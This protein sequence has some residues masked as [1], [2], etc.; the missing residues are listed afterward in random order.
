MERRDIMSGKDRDIIS[1]LRELVKNVNELLEATMADVT[2]EQAHWIPP[3]V[4]MPIGAHY[5][6]VVLSQDGAVNGMLKG[7]SPLFAAAW[8]AKTELSE[9]LS[10][11]PGTSC[12][13]HCCGTWKIDDGGCNP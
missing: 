5:A 12:R 13:S 9:L 2:P 3:G 7:G 10:W 11:R 6:H 4:A 8:A 1:W